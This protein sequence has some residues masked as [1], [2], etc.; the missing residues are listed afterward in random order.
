MHASP[1]HLSRVFREQTGSS[2]H[3]YRTEARL[4]AGLERIADGEGLAGLAADLGFA[5]QAHLTDRFR[6]VFG[7]TPHAWRAGLH[8]RAV[9]SS[10]ILKADLGPAH[11]A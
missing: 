8:S 9:H 4:R 5:S 10:R 6:R 7:V 11:I 1:F 3:A 2:L